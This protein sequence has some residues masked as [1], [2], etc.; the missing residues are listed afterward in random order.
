[1]ITFDRNDSGIVT[2]FPRFLSKLLHENFPGLSSP[3]SV[4][5]ISDKIFQKDVKGSTIS[6][7]FGRPCYGCRITRPPT[8]NYLYCLI[9]MD[10]A[11]RNSAKTF[12]IIMSV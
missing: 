2:E 5:N 4:R 6:S 8:K 12:P 7:Q 1:M 9:G 3:N 11:L 10:E